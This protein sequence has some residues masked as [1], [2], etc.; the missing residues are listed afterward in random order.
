MS[1]GRSTSVVEHSSGF[2]LRPVGEDDAEFLYSLYASTR[3]EELAVTGWSD[4]QKESFLRNQFLAQTTHYQ[5][6]FADGTFDVILL[7]GN[8]IGRL[9]VHS[10]E[11]KS[12]IVDIALLPEFR[13]QGIGSNLIRELQESCATSGRALSIHVEKF[14]PALNLYNRLGFTTEGDEGVYWYMEWKPQ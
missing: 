6:Y 10:T 8:P 11:R 9:Y 7:Q 3:T 13:G 12:H 4:E 14:N 1:F 5:T 2:A